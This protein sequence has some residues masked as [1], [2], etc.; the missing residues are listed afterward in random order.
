M[1]LSGFEFP[2]YHSS[3]FGVGPLP[4]WSAPTQGACLLRLEAPRS[5]SR[6]PVPA[7]SGN[8]HGPSARTHRIPRGDGGGSLARARLSRSTVA[9]F[10][11]AARRGAR[12]HLREAEE[13]RGGL[14]CVRGD[15]P[16]VQ[17]REGGEDAILCKTLCKMCRG[18]NL[19]RESKFLPLRG[20]V[21]LI[22]SNVR[23]RKILRKIS[24]KILQQ[25]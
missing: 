1:R 16:L 8:S 17:V 3:P 5:A 12:A 21:F 15:L 19:S 14:C 6:P 22:Q 18:P 24:R 11:G 7:A 4:V 13:R 25:A 20:G 9:G 10:G 2:P 23:A